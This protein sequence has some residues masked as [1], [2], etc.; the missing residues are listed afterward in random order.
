[1]V[2]FDKKIL[3][4]GCGGVTQ[5]TLPLLLK[6]LDVPPRNVT[7]MDFVDNRSRV[8]AFLDK[9]VTYVQEQLTAAN[10]KELLSRYL[11][12]GDIFLDLAWNIDT[13]RVIEWCHDNNVLYVNTSIEEWEPYIERSP[14]EFTLYYRHRDLLDLIKGWGP[15]S[16]TAIVD[17]GANPGLVSHFTKQALIEIAQKILQ[18]KPLDPRKK[19]LERALEDNNFPLLAQ[20]TNT[21]VIHISERDTQITHD[22]KKVN[23]FVNTWSIEGLIEEGTAPAELGWGTHEPAL[24]G[25]HSHDFGPKNQI[26]L[27]SRGVDTW[28]RSWVPSGPIVGMVIRHGEA[29]GIS[30]RLTLWEHGK[31]VYRPTVHY[32]Y[33]PTDSALSSLH[34]LRMRGFKPQ[35]NRRILNNDI[36]SGKD[37]VG[38]L[39]MG[40]DF[41]SWWI[42]SV[43][44]ID[45]ARQLVPEQNSTTLQVAI[46]VVA[47]VIYAIKN[48]N[49]GLCLPDDIDHVE[50]LKIA[51]PYLGEF[52]STP[53]DWTPLSDSKQFFKKAPKE[54]DLW[55]F[56]NFLIKPSYY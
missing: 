13:C 12:P 22:P 27:S 19:L 3:V 41:N 56:S 1:M 21:K 54:Q 23:E 47:A 31:A 25:A 52:I 32:A 26:F 40:H 24:D 44:D 33:C 17:H 15:K 55:Q 50:I 46:S 14:A 39:L 29:Y 11:K 37:E 49:R 4:V 8:K 35:E 16:T 2:K 28:V 42:G 9:G 38:C 10:Y 5:C 48:P 43:L 20:L 53:V 30:E 36:I 7:V 51:K 34:E 18:E 45:E 6:L